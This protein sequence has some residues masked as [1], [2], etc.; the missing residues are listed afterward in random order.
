MEKYLTVYVIGYILCLATLY[1]FS[2]EGLGWKILCSIIA[3]FW[4]F[5]VVPGIGI[6]I[7]RFVRRRIE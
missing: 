6:W 5:I 7:G 4:P 3:I 1:F 2:D